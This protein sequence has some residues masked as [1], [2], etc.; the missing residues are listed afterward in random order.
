[1][2]TELKENVPTLMYLTFITLQ[3]LPISSYC[4]LSEVFSVVTF[5]IM[6]KFFSFPV[7]LFITLVLPEMVFW[8]FLMDPQDSTEKRIR[9]RNINIFC[10]MGMWL[11]NGLQDCV[12]KLKG[13]EKY[14][15]KKETAIKYVMHMALSSAFFMDAVYNINKDRKQQEGRFKVHFLLLIF[16]HAIVIVYLS[17]AVGIFI[18]FFYDSRHT[19]STQYNT[20]SRYVIFQIFVC[21]VN[22]L[23]FAIY[24]HF[25]KRQAN[26]LENSNYYCL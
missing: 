4:V 3:A 9:L 1:M 14:H 15:C 10:N 12:F 7:F 5:R 6:N 19:V 25:S 11:I 13:F 20:H 2:R 21:I 18:F 22:A 26:N 23:V 17:Y 8:K 24:Y 16:E